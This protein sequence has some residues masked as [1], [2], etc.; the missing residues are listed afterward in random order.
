MKSVCSAGPLTMPSERNTL[1]A[2]R[3]GGS[4]THIV[5]LIQKPFN[6]YVLA[7]QF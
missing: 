7:S 1:I 5:V 4:L 2:F 6:P 3:E